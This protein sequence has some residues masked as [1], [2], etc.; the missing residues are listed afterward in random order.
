[1]SA[2]RA[3]KEASRQDENKILERITKRYE[4]VDQQLDE[5][6]AK[7]AHLGIE[8][9]QEARRPAKPR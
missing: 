4:Q 6:E 1:M 5:L 9:N 8:Q 7:L 3:D 2:K